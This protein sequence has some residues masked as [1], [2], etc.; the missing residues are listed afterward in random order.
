[1]TIRDSKEEFLAKI[2]PGDL[3]YLCNHGII[4]NKKRI[5]F[6]KYE[7]AP[8][9]NSGHREKYWCYMAMDFHHALYGDFPNNKD[10]QSV[11]NSPNALWYNRNE[12]F[13]LSE[14]DGPILNVPKP[15]ESSSGKKSRFRL[16]E[17]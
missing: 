12:F 5:V 8:Y 4:T 16:G 11:V 2:K 13:E 10:P 1:M 15:V 9:E 3:L 7:D 6:C 17:E 14:I